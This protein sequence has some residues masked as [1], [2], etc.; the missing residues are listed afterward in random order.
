MVARPLN[1]V[2]VLP[3]L[4][5][6]GV[7]RGTLE[8]GSYLAQQGH[9]SIVISGGGRMVPSLVVSGS[10]HIRWRHIGEKSPR[11]L[12]YIW[13]LRR[14]LMER[15]VDVLHLRSRLPAWIGFWAWRL[16]PPLRRP[17]LV[18]TFHGFYSVNRYSAIMAQGEKVIA[19]SRA[20]AD[21]VQ[22][23]YNVPRT[24]ITVIH[25]GV[26]P[27]TFSPAN[28]SRQR[29]QT[30]RKRWQLSSIQG[31][32][33]LMPGRLTRLKGHDLLLRSLAQVKSHPWTVLCVG[34]HQAKP[35][36]YRELIQQI[37]A[38]GLT[39]RVMLRDHC[40]DMPAAMLLADVV[41][42]ASIKPES[43]GRTAIEA[44]A[45]GKPVIAPAHGGSLE[46]IVD[47]ETGW[48]FQPSDADSLAGVLTKA[49]TEE[50]RRLQMGR[51][52][53]QRVI[54]KFTLERMCRE[55]VTL[56]QQMAN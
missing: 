43:F 21:H 34:D 52:G 51:N 25:R 15:R 16:V 9:T 56:Y 47:G 35:K 32:L 22:T 29:V 44:Q 12:A 27:G 55:T 18:T 24:R 11:S 49:V 46:T 54:A 45:M 19:V 8:M 50:K 53:Q 7:E 13:P 17:R 2:Q 48:H 36:L 14:L 41:V 38:L 33:L 26:D 23:V 39:Q 37:E 20:I 3:E 40:E 30:L 31:P 6:G 42:S 28:I 1:I 4:E 5:S 10:E